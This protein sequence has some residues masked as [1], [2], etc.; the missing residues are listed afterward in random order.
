MDSDRDE[1]CGKKSFA[2]IA[3]S[4]PDFYIF[5]DFCRTLQVRLRHRPNQITD[6]P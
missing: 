1:L 4:R 3:D 5:Q 2:V 6:L